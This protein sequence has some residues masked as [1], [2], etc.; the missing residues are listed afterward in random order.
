MVVSIGGKR[1]Y[2]WR[3]VDHDGDV[4]DILVQ[5]RKDTKA[6]NRFFRKLLKGQGEVP[7]DITTDKLGSYAAAKRDVMSAV[8]HC[9]E[10]YANNR[11]EVSH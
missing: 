9:C 8:P 2:L 10:R 11:A 7:S 6:A 5:K 4:L 3:A 1:R